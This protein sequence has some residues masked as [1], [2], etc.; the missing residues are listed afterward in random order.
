MQPVTVLQMVGGTS[1]ADK[2]LEAGTPMVVSGQYR[3]QPGSR[4]RTGA[5]VASGGT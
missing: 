5:A 4:V 2:G 3:L 1:V